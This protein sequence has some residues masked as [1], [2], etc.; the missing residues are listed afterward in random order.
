MLGFDVVKDL[1]VAQ[2]LFG[3]LFAVTYGAMLTA[4]RRYGLFN[5]Y[6][7]LL[8]GGPDCWRW[9]LGFL[10]LNILPLFH[11]TALMFFFGR[12]YVRSDFGLMLLGLLVIGLQS[13]AVFG[14]HRVLTGL[15][16]FRPRIFFDGMSVELTRRE[17]E[18]YPGEYA[19]P[20][21]LAGVYYIL[22]PPE[23]LALICS[24]GLMMLKI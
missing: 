21:T 11:F 5:T 2:Q 3:L 23:L 14:Y 17:G 13:I 18:E 16:Y 4:S 6:K 10:F 8:Y 9:G 7:A 15:L 1:N 12:I 20:H 24:L 22:V 19:W